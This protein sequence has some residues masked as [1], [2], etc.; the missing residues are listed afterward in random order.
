MTIRD[1]AEILH[2]KVLCGEDKLDTP[3]TV[4]CCSDLMSDVLA[5][6]DDEKS[7]YENGIANGFRV[8][9]ISN[10]DADWADNIRKELD[11]IS[12]DD[13]KPEHCCLARLLLCLFSLEKMISEPNIA[14]I[15]L[16]DGETGIDEKT[17]SA[18]IISGLYGGERRRISPSW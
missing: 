1:M 5:F 8:Y 13:I 18:D 15:D 3:V 11:R 4:A 6:V 9:R 2:A 17:E 16:D 10:D 7:V 12:Y 14:N